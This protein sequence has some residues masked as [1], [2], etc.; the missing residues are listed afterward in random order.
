MTSENVTEHE[1]VDPV[2]AVS[3]KAVD[4]SPTSKLR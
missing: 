3:A 4:T 2:A 1:A